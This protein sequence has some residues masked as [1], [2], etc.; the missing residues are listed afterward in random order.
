MTRENTSKVSESVVLA[1]PRPIFTKSWHP[2][3]HGEIKDATEKA[4]ESLNWEIIDRYYSIRP[5]SKCLAVW[6]IKNGDLP[7]FQGSENCLTW[8]N[9]IDMT[10]SAAWGMAFNE[11]VCSNLMIS[12]TKSWVVFRKHTGSLTTEELYFYAVESLKIVA[13]RFERFGKWYQGLKEISLTYEQASMLSVFAMNRG[14]IPQAKFSQFWEKYD[15]KSSL[16]KENKRTLFAF[17]N[18]NTELMKENNM[19]VQLNKQVQLQYFLQYEAIELLKRSKEETIR[20]I[21]SKEVIDVAFKTFQAESVKEKEE[22]RAKSFKIKDRFKEEQKKA[23]EKSGEAISAKK[24][25]EAVTDTDETEKEALSSSHAV[26]VKKHEAERTLKCGLKYHSTHLGDSDKQRRIERR[27][28]KKRIKQ[29]GFL[30]HVDGILNSTKTTEDDRAFVREVNKSEPEKIASLRK[31][32]VCRST[33]FATDKS[34][35]SCGVAC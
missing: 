34:C 13:T 9:S 28:T 33:I 8:R 1:E 12:S 24:T 11:L 18:A 32:G 35:P 27:E 14:Y 25:K 15:G 19:L 4:C 16:Y 21:E 2:Y 10:H 3:S 26:R 17:V 31:C 29:E 22:I 5:N 20:M 23:K 30:N 6:K 7:I